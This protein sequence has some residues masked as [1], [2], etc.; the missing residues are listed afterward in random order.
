MLVEVLFSLSTSMFKINYYD[1]LS[2]QVVEGLPWDQVGVQFPAG[3]YQMLDLGRVRSDSG[4]YLNL[5]LGN[6]R[7]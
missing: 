7:R 2:G 3:S 5:K 6:T 1:Q 4:Q